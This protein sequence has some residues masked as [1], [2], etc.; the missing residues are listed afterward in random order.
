MVYHHNE[1]ET[2]VT[3]G[4]NKPSTR[5][6]LRE[7]GACET[8]WMQSDDGDCLIKNSSHMASTK[9]SK[10][11]I[12]LRDLCLSIVLLYIEAGPYT[13]LFAVR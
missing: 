12:Y 6:S 11:E 7:S 1:F 3:R 2:L 4:Q 9:S 10:G 5:L 8:R 13:P